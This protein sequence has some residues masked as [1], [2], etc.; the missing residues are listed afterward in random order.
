MDSNKVFSELKLIWS[1]TL[2]IGST[3]SPKKQSLSISS[4]ENI[5]GCDEQK[6]RGGQKYSSPFSSSCRIYRS[7]KVVQRMYK[8][9]WKACA[10]VLQV[11][12]RISMYKDMQDRLPQ[13]KT[14]TR[15]VQ[16]CN[17]RFVGTRQHQ[18]G[19]DQQKLSAVQTWGMQRMHTSWSG[20][21]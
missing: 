7:A 12:T 21:N 18:S 10:K 20:P 5:A 16:D 3:P 4:A 11:C 13:C 17:I 1:N 2:S 9:P 14:C 19:M 6:S 8:T 15:L